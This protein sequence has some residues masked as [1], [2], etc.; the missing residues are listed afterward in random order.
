MHHITGGKNL[1]TLK[2]LKSVKRALAQVVVSGIETVKRVV[3]NEDV[4]CSSDK[5]VYYLLL[6]G[7][8]LS[9]VLGVAGIDGTATKS[10][11]IAEIYDVFGIEAARVVIS[12]EIKYIMDQYGIRIDVRHLLLLADV[13]T[14]KGEVLGITRSGIAKMRES[15]LMLAS[16][17]KTTDHLFDAA[18]HA[19]QDHIV[20]VSECIITGSRMPLGTGMF[21]V[22]S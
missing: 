3:I 2:A 20:G 17:E 7:Y 8:G 6:E 18:V 11:H 13:M 15:V 19:R 4:M 21:D 16:F 1:S 12:S 9:Q 14:F 5:K 10:N 22:L